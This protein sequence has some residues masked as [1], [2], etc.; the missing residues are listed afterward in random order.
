MA[1]VGERSADVGSLAG[2]PDDL[3]DKY[4]QRARDMGRSP[5]EREAALLFTVAEA[6]LAEEEDEPALKAAKDV[7]SKFAA[8]QDEEGV[9]DAARIVINVLIYQGKRKEA[10]AMARDELARI[11]VK[12]DKIGEAK[13]LLSVAEVN[14]ERM[15]LKKREEALTMASDAAKLFKAQQDLK[16]EA[17]ALLVVMS[18]QLRRRDDRK[19]GNSEGMATA[20]QA[21]ALFKQVDDR[22]GQGAAL[23]GIALACVR[24][25]LLDIPVPT[26]LPGGAGWLGVAKEAVR[27]F[28]EA[29]LRKMEAFERICLA[30]WLIADNPR[31]GLRAAEEALAFCREI[32][33]RQEPAA[34]T[35][36]VQA[37]LSI[38]D[39]SRAWRVK[40]AGEAIR[41]AKQGLARFRTLGD[42]FGMGQALS[43]LV[44]AHMVCDETDAALKAASQAL[45]IFRSIEDETSE[46]TILQVMSGLHLK[47]NQ[48]DKAEKAARQINALS[49][50]LQERAVALETIYEAHLRKND[51][52]KARNVAE[53]LLSLCEEEGDKKRE[54][55]V[56]LM[57]SNVHYAEGDYTEAV[58]VAREAQ[59]ILNDVGAFKEEAQTL[60]V[61]AEA[62]AAN[63]EHQAALRAADR[64]RKLF[65]SH[66]SPDQEATMLFLIA[67]IR[68]LVVTTASEIGDK[69]SDIFNSNVADAK[70]AA[71]EA[72]VS[73]RRVGDDRLAG[74]ALA[75]SAQVLLANLE[76]EASQKAADEAMATFKELNDEVN[77]ACV[78]CVQA[79]IQLVNGSNNRALKLAETALNIYQARGD[80]RGEFV[81]ASIREH[82]LG[83]PEPEL[84]EEPLEQQWTEEEW[85]QWEEWQRQQQGGGQQPQQPQH[86][87]VAVQKAKKKQVALTGGPLDMA[88][89]SQE[90]IQLRVSEIVQNT[91]E[92]DEDDVVG[93]DMP[94]MQLGVTSKTAVV[95]R[96]ALSE[97]LPGVQLPFTMVFDYPSINA[98]TEH[99][100]DQ[101]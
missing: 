60:R 9:V 83:P 67:Q 58:A 57:V 75:I 41:K 15:G 5:A 51:F 28:Q 34:L 10:D 93:L 46:S 27:T 52:S 73:A 95:L 19:E 79:D 59:A 89:V 31:K 42:E 2:A 80:A 37:H 47:K 66:G 87:Q 91:I 84:P 40:E 38:R 71:D 49:T 21:L 29:K 4:A 77:Q 72:V 99:V 68:L 35:A 64:S 7:R 81:A 69:S 94:L 61:V 50:S 96:N 30:Q 23:H 62:H 48:P 97:E 63:K 92:I 6:H 90:A 101:L 98:M 76:V 43:A 8:L 74:S 13:L 32:G 88:N 22:R 25:G 54:A 82:I 100:M 18:C 1:P 33:S 24:C 20:K 56:R 39:I 78:M 86:Q 55:I 45:E 14:S 65:Q 3:S 53:E 36:V 11:R 12:G 16:M 17:Q 70:S 44:T 26:D 85:R